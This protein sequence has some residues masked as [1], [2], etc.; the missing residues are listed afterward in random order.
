MITR[1][2][3]YDPITKRTRTFHSNPE[4][5]E[6]F[7]KSDFDVSDIVDANTAQFAMVDER[8]GWK[9]EMHRIASIPLHVMHELKLKNI[10]DPGGD[11]QDD[12]ALLRWL[13]DP[14]NRKFRTRPGHV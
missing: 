6:Y 2:L 7:I 11:V 12:A 10:I 9:G 8:A 14:A 13:N 4:G 1:K 3:D 5:T